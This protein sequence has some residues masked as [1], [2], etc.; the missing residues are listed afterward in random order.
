[1]CLF[2][3][4]V[5]LSAAELKPH[6]CPA[7]LLDLSQ[8]SDKVWHTGPLYELRLFPP[9]NYFLLLKSNLHSIHFQMKVESEYTELSPVE[10]SW[11]HCY[12]C[13]TLQTCQ[14]FADD[15]VVLAT[16]SGPAIGSQKL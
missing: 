11:G 14:I 8:T 10:V 4:G 12:T 9:L 15:I 2:P 6:D 3:R 7:A 5:P 16:D 1:M 13:Y